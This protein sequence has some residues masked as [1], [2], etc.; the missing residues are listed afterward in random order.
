MESSNEMVTRGV[1]HA[2]YDMTIKLQIIITR[3][4]RILCI[5]DDKQENRFLKEC[6]LLAANLTQSDLSSAI[7][8]R[9]CSD[10]VHGGGVGQPAVSAHCALTAHCAVPSLV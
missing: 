10:R 9:S 7:F 2:G 1:F 6:R 5:V 8:T 3:R 4:T